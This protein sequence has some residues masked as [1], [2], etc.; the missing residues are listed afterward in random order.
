M[1]DVVMLEAALFQL[2]AASAGIDPQAAPQLGLCITVMAS[3]VAAGRGGVNA[4]VANDIEFAFNDLNA[5]LDELPQADADRVAPLL[6]TLRRDVEALKAATALDPVIIT[7]IRTFQTKLRERM[8]AIERQTFVEGG[9]EPLPHRPEALRDEA[10][11]LARQLAAAGFE[12]P[13][14]SAFIADPQ[15]VRLH[16]LRDLADELDVIAG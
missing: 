15:S 2:C 3:A 6:A 10:V 9:A 8:K 14:L 7:H 11:P 16:S 5:A 12:T 13:A 1:T 4:A